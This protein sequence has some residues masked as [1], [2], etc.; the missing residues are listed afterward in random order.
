MSTDSAGKAWDA[1]FQQLPAERQEAVKKWF[2]LQSYLAHALGLAQE[3]WMKYV[4]WAFDNPF[5]YS[6]IAEFP[7]LVAAFEAGDG[8]ERAQSSAA[9]IGKQELGLAAQ[10]NKTPGN[11]LFDFMLGRTEDAS[12]EDA[13]AK[14]NND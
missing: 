8:F 6:F 5:D 13:E 10:D 2:G 14:K 3:E 11:S 7:E 1:A 12:Q 4:Q 9:L